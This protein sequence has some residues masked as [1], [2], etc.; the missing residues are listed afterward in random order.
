MAVLRVGKFNKKRAAQ[1]QRKE[2]LP[3]QIE[4]Y[5]GG[6]LKKFIKRSTE[7]GKVAKNVMAALAQKS[8][9][10]VLEQ[11]RQGVGF[12]ATTPQAL[13]LATMGRHF[14]RR[15]SQGR[16]T[17]RLKTPML[18]GRRRDGKRKN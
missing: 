12:T 14:V 11:A 7:L 13:A 2:D 9:N 17:R 15:L 4:P 1:A 18:K 8:L 6:T 5:E 10:A 16:R 3:A